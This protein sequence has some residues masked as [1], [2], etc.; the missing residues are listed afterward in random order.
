MV[1]GQ[2]H[3]GELFAVFEPKIWFPEDIF[4]VPSHDFMKF[5]GIMH[6]WSGKTSIDFDIQRSNVK[7]TIAIIV[8]F[9]QPTLGF[10]IMSLKSLIKFTGMMQYRLQ[11]TPVAILPYA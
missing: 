7:V 4:E 6:Y 3:S 10:P 8:P 5:T 2:G 11:K 1:K 9:L